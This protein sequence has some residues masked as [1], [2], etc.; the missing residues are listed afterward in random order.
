MQTKKR[1]K[2]VKKNVDVRIYDVLTQ[3]YGSYKAKK[4]Y[5]YIMLKTEINTINAF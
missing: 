3:I 5:R 4:K 2:R 1:I